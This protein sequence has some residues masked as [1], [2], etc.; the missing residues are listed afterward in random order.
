MILLIHVAG[1]HL[2]LNRLR[3]KKIA[4]RWRLSKN[5]IASNALLF[6]T[7]VGNSRQLV[8]IGADKFRYVDLGLEKGSDKSNMDEIWSKTTNIKTNKPKQDQIAPCKQSHVY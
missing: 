2:T 7:T 3:L 6:R 4:A 5:K 8:R 1:L